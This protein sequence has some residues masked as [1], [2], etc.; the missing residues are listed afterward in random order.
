MTLT[1]NTYNYMLDDS[2]DIWIIQ[3]YDSTNQYCHYFAQ[4]WE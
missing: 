3:A 2:D 1:R 4:F